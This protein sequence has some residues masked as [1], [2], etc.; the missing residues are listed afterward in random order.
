MASSGTHRGRRIQ[1]SDATTAQG[2]YTTHPSVLHAMSCV[3]RLAYV[4][5]FQSL[6]IPR[7]QHSV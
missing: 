3:L 5:I 4:H 7:L 2:A 6:L 1:N